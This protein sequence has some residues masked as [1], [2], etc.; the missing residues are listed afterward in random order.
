MISNS[1]CFTANIQQPLFQH[2][3]DQ[4]QHDLDYNRRT[5]RLN[6]DDV[7]LIRLW[8]KT[9][10]RGMYRIGLTSKNNVKK[11]MRVEHWPNNQP[12]NQISIVTVAGSV[13]L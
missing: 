3:L 13:A 9:G 5:D 6:E 4:L 11:L 2:L 7:Q 10:N 1:F 12:C 8:E